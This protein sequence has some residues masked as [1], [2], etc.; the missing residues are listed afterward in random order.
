MLCG[1]VG[2]RT[3]IVVR[4]TWLTVELMDIC[5]NKEVPCSDTSTWQCNTCRTSVSSKYCDY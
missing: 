1:V 2:T 4:G 5:P 3:E